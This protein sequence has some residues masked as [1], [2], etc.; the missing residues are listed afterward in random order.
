MDDEE[1]HDDWRE[2]LMAKADAM[3]GETV[4]SSMMRVPISPDLVVR[5][6]AAA[7]ARGIS[8]DGY[9]TRSVCKQLAVDLDEPIER[10][11]AFTPR[12]IE[13][14]KGL[15][16]QKGARTRPHDNTEGFGDWSWP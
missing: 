9:V 2:R 15:K 3:K 4:T 5:L 11:L 10:L 12:P 1:E 7:E 13:Y 6:H 14:S 16:G 8:I